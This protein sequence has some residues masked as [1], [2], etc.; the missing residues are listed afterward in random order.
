[1]RKRAFGDACQEAKALGGL[2]LSFEC[3]DVL[4]HHRELASDHDGDINVPR[5][6]TSRTLPLKEA[7]RADATLPHEKRHDDHRP[8]VCRS[9]KTLQFLRARIAQ[10]GGG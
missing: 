2:L 1:M 5:R 8:R 9:K 3:L 4:K 7:Q 10:R 6:E